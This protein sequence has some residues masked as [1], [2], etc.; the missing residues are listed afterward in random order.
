MWKINLTGDLVYARFR[1]VGGHIDGVVDDVDVDVDGVQG[2]LVST[3]R[4]KK[5][6]NIVSAP[7]FYYWGK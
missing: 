7:L 4:Y 6:N 3:V 5:R 2:T 1:F